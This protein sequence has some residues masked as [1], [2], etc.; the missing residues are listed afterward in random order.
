MKARM[1]LALCCAWGMLVA[2]GAPALAVEPVVVVKTDRS[3]IGPTAST[4]FLAWVE[5]HH[6][7]D[8]NVRAQAIGSATSF[9][10]NPRGTG[11]FT[12]EI[13]G[14]TL[15]YEQ[16]VLG[17]YESDLVMV[18]LS[19]R[20][21]LDVP[22]GVNTNAS[23]F[24]PSLS[25]SRFLFGRS[26]RHGASIVL[27]DTTTSA[28]EV[29]YSKTETDRRQFFILPTQI[30]GNYAVWQQATISKRTDELIRSDIFLYDIAAA[31]TTRIPN[32]DIE[33]PVQ[34]GLSV[35][36]D[37]VMYFGRS[38]IACGENAQL[39]SRELDGTETVLYELPTN[40]DFGSSHAVDN[41]NNT[42]DVYFDRGDCRRLEF[43]NIWKL[44]GV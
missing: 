23:E 28:S 12:G 24:S 42:T 13:D 4:T 43:G 32:A 18:D 8:P 37:G 6:L 2:T 41:P 36:S 11:A 17:E 5:F 29:V 44:S 38:S 20:T 7:F 39:I 16:F 1:L 40:R 30:N 33:R 21:E 31:T 9:R 26:I 10:V 27:F 3:E 14:S 35:D 25:G 15:L 34:Y 22:D 19:T